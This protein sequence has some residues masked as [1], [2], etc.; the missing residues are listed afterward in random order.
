MTGKYNR[1]ALLMAS[2]QEG[3]GGKRRAIIHGGLCLFA[4]DSL[5]NA[6]PIPLEDCEE[7]AL[8]VALATYLINAGIQISRNGEKQE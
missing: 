2:H 7:H 8:R 4:G 6:K 5:S 1:Y 3:C